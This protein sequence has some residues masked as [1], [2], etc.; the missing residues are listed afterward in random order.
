MDADLGVLRHGLEQLL[1]L[2][3]GDLGVL[4]NIRFVTLQR[5]CLHEAVGPDAAIVEGARREAKE[6]IALR[7][8]E[9]PDEVRVVGHEGHE[10]C[11]L[12]LLW[13]SLQHRTRSRQVSLGEIRHG[14]LLEKHQIR[15]REGEPAVIG[16]PRLCVAAQPESRKAQ[17]P[18]R[19]ERAGIDA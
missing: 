3:A 7:F 11:R 16:L 1:E 17:A 6:Q 10:R 13:R 19:I 4:A 12:H 14:L 15:G 5:G 8:V 2:S 18:K 9:Q